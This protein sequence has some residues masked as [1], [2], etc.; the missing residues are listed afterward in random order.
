MR[1][2]LTCSLFLILAPLLSNRT[3]A[4]SLTQEEMLGQAEE[5]VLNMADSDRFSGTLLIAK[6]SEVLLEI[7]L[8]EASKRFHVPIDMHTKFN[9]GSMN[10][11]FTAVGIMQLRE[12]G[13]LKLSDPLS[14]F[15][16]ESWLPKSIT[17]EISLQ[18]LLSHTSGLGSYFNDE[19]FASSRLRFSELEDYKPLVQGDTLAFEPGSNYAYSNTGMLLLGVVIEQAS[20]ENYFDYMRQHIFETAGMKH[21]DSYFMNQ[22]VENLAIGYIRDPSVPSGWRNNI[23]DHVLR[24][25]PAGGGFST[26]GDLQ[27]F[28]LALT[29]GKLVGAES[30]ELL[31]ADPRNQGYGSGFGI[32]TL[33]SGERVVGHNG[34]F[35]GVNG[36]L[37]IFLESGYIVAVLTNYDHAASRASE[38]IRGLIGR[39][40][41]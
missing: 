7:P 8:G 28:A 2:L 13:K 10:K 32:Q 30:R 3:E 24:G 25:G 11:M 1:Q 14:K 12:A 31:W 20:G 23:Y 22:P 33:P 16:D 40:V 18:H 26:V 39:V 41:E 15:V 29:G 4:Q 27:R 19:F 5:F 21:T 6:G 9:L 37:D 36:N 38:V 35:P 34:G 17:E